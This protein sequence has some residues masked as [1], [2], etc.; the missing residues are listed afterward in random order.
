MSIQNMNIIRNLSF[1]ALVI[2]SSACNKELEVGKTSKTQTVSSG[3]QGQDT[4]D[5]MN[6][7]FDL[8]EELQ[9]EASFVADEI[10]L[11]RDNASLTYTFLSRK[12]YSNCFDSGDIE[13]K[14]FTYK[15]IQSKKLGRTIHLRAYV[16][17]DLKQKSDVVRPTLAMFHGG[18]WRAGAPVKWFPAARYFASRGIVS[19][20]FQYRLGGTH[21]STPFDAV[22]DA[23]S[24]MRW[25]R[26]YSSAL[27]VNPLKIAAVGDSAGGHLALTTAL[28]D[29]VFDEN[30]NDLKIS[31]KPQFVFALYPIVNTDFVPNADSISPVKLVSALNAVPTVILQGDADAQPRTQPKEVEAFCRKQSALKRNSCRYVLF[32]KL[33]HAFYPAHKQGT[34][35]TLVHLEKFMEAL[36]FLNDSNIEGVDRVK[37]ASEICKSNLFYQ[38]WAESY[39]YSKN[40]K[41][42]W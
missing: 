34:A 1:T 41:G 29:E 12:S 5:E 39:G 14:V 26:K 25:L 38:E 30:T 10:K 8:T 42:I 40:P 37:S 4:N 18:G 17:S 9:D 21:K 19:V 24:A 27:G 36:K 2:G 16:F 3:N 33:E 28:V 7:E 13:E 23:A 6:E 35:S 32:P 15:T 31:S 11:K 22:A 20:V